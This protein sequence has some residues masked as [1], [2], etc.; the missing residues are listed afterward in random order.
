MIGSKGNYPR[1]PSW[2]SQA[3]F[4]KPPNWLHGDALQEWNRIAPTLEAKR[5]TTAADQ[6]ALAMYCQL[7]ARW[8]ELNKRVEA[9]GVLIETQKGEMK[10]NPALTAQGMLANQSLRY[11]RHFGFTP[12]SRR[13]LGDST[14]GNSPEED[15]LDGF[16]NGE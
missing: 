11:A 15:D 4:P 1:D 7:C 6:M 9:E 16:I 8:L 13:E 2:K 14:T 3:D 10:I 12:H 5:L